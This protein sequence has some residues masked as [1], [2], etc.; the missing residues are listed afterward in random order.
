MKHGLMLLPLIPAVG[1]ITVSFFVAFAAS[2][3]ESRIL[4][5]YAKF[6]I[7]LLWVAALIIAC[8]VICKIAGDKI[9]VFPPCGVGVEKY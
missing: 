6:I 3:A 5:N 9:C 4:K 2:K 1:M 7:G 8:S